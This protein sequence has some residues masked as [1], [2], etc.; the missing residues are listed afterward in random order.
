MCAHLLPAL[1]YINCLQ[2]SA[3]QRLMDDQVTTLQKAVRQ[4]TFE[5]DQLAE[6]V[7]WVM[8]LVTHMVPSHI[9]DITSA[10]NFHTYIIRAEHDVMWCDDVQKGQHV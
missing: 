8:S 6:Q 3:S 2:F 5:R 7:K 4:L 9:S 1:L 10:V